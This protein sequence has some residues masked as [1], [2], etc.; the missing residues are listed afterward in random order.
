MPYNA[1][2]RTSIDRVL[3]VLAGLTLG[4]CAGTS[5]STAPAEEAPVRDTEVVVAEASAAVAEGAPSTLNDG[6]R[7]E[8][9]SVSSYLGRFEV[10]SREVYVQREHLVATLGLEP[11]D[12]V[13]DI[14][15]G[16]G[17][18]ALLMAH[19]VGPEG[20]V[21]AVDISP[22]FIGYLEERA[23]ALDLP[24]L[25][26]VLC[27][28]KSTR[29]EEGSVDAVF[30][31][32]TYHHFEHPADTLESIRRALRPGGRFVVVDFHR[33]PGVSRPWML[34]HVRCGKEQVIAEIEAAGFRRLE[35]PHV[36]GM[37]DN[38][39]LAFEWP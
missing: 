7:D 22:R 25:R 33:I 26:P 2:M 1:R 27:D 38:Y 30:T 4:S 16:T 9:M 10:E 32:D 36:P 24:Q 29:L 35:D 23:Y 17:L 14:G 28:E 3:F 12:A 34:N 31:C 19:E 18:H 39:V 8:G 20:R 15:S 11:G 37:T 13:A 5:N 6:F 21:Y